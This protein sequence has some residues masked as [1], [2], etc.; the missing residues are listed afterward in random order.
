MIAA[1]DKSTLERFRA[2]YAECKP[3]FEL[4][5]GEAVQKAVP[6]EAHS[7]L[8]IVLC[9]LLK[10]LG[11]KP[12]PELTLAISTGG[13]KEQCGFDGYE[14]P[15]GARRFRQ[16]IIEILNEIKLAWPASPVQ[17]IVD[18]G[19]NGEDYLLIERRALAIRE[20]Q[21]QI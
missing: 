7:L 1:T 3:H 18:E 19:H 16:K 17:V 4:L 21:E 6:T 12:S 14:G 5:D 11:F 20:A 13:V 8:Q 15:R 10:E 9:F 2:K